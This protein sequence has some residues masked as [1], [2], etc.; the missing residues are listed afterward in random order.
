MNAIP[1]RRGWVIAVTL[2][3]A[4][5]L[6]PLPL[7]ET[8]ARWWPDWVALTL[9][10]WCLA[11]PQRVG[12][13]SA[14]LT[15]LLLD[16]LTGTL[17]GQH[18]LALGVVAYLTLKLHQ[19]IR[20]FPRWQQALSVLLLLALNQLLQLWVYGI[21]G[22]PT[23]GWAYWAPSLAGL[24]AWTPIYHGLRALRRSWHVS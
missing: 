23:R 11:L 15:G 17:L 24:L 1:A 7:P 19:R 14:W 18:A 16:A 5:A 3:I 6:A 8:A 22:H 21:T 2:L 12:V 9:I 13:G 20:I 4:L 10:Y